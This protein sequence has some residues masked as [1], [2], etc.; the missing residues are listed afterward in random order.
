MR[1]DETTLSML[2][3]EETRLKFSR[4][5]K[6]LAAGREVFGVVFCIKRVSD[7]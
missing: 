3:P 5:T 7:S 4:I 1:E 6:I 2:A